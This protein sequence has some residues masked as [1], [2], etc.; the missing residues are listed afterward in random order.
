MRDRLARRLFARCARGGALRALARR[1]WPDTVA[2]VDGLRLVLRPADDAVQRDMYLRGRLPDR[3]VLDALA[4]QVRGRRCLIA[5]LAPGAGYRVVALGAVAGP[6]SVVRAFEPDAAAAARLTRSLALNRLVARVS[7]DTGAPVEAA[8]VGPAD[9]DPQS[10]LLDPPTGAGAPVPAPL[11]RL[12]EG[13]RTFERVAVSLDVDGP[14]DPALHAL[15][16]HA[17]IAAQPYAVLI[18]IAPGTTP[19]G[20]NRRRDVFATLSGRG[21]RLEREADGRAL[22][23]RDGFAGAPAARPGVTR[24]RAAAAGRARRTRR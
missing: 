9:R 22:F 10:I 18:G 4:A 23:V 21:Y 13:C 5:D 17:S 8:A 19:P 3:D 7:I 15:L 1:F 16:R 12:L 6:G 24:R 11:M 20:S 2:H 14:E